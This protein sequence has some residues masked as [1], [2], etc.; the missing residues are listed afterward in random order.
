ML[1][2]SHRC[3]PCRSDRVEH[4]NV[5]ELLLCYDLL[6][7]RYAQMTSSDYGVCCTCE[8]L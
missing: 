2:K 8:G 3:H 7:C 4:V 1:S 5:Y 6:L